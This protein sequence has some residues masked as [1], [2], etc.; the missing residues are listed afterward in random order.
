MAHTAGWRSAFIGAAVLAVAC[1]FLIREPGWAGHT[2]GS[3][4]SEA[5]AKRPR[6]ARPALIRLAIGIG[7]GSAAMNAMGSFFVLSAV[8]IEVTDSRAGLLA[9]VGSVV[10]LL[11]RLGIGARADRRAGEHLRL[12]SAL[13]AAG[14]V[15]LLLLAL[16]DAAL[17]L[18]AAI[19]GYGAGWGWAG[20]F[21]FAVASSH[22]A[23]PGRA[24]GLTQVGASTGGCLGPLCFGFTAA[25]VGYLLAWI[26]AAVLLL[27]AAVVILVG[28]RAL[29]AAGVSRGIDQDVPTTISSHRPR[30]PTTRPV[31][32]H[33]A[34]ESTDWRPLPPPICPALLLPDATVNC[35][36]AKPSPPP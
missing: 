34:A 25:H 3:A 26:G 21:T 14:S 35:R 15:G 28:W 33:P 20:L 31:E 30:R 27:A 17:L 6:F 4:A 12:V 8:S 13:C 2:V 36:S 23:A 7:M 19:I 1:G 29:S 24:T 16:G 9:A 11:V 18:P 5:V 32:T 10:S 22:P